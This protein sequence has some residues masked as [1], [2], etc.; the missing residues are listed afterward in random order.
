[1]K[2]FFKKLVPSVGK[3]EPSEEQKQEMNSEKCAFCQGPNPDRKWLG[4]MW[5]T[6]CFRKAKKMAKKMI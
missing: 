5:H 1:M 4:Q 3:E 6:D 2:D